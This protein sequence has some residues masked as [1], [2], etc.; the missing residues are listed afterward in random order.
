[1][2]TLD[3]ALKDAVAEAVAPLQRT[4]ED[5]VRRVTAAI[6]PPYVP[7]AEACRILG[8]CRSTVDGMIERGELVVKRAGRRVLVDVASLRVPSAEQVETEMFR[9]RRAA[10]R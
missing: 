8:C 9:A 1:M 10:G 4:V 7:I 3:Q 5:L 2:A 6:P